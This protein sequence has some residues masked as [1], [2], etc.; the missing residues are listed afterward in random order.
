MVLVGVTPIEVQSYGTDAG[1]LDELRASWPPAGAGSTPVDGYRSTDVAALDVVGAVRLTDR[2]GVA[3]DQPQARQVR[4]ASLR[5]VL[6]Q[7]EDAQ[8]AKRLFLLQLSQRRLFVEG[9]VEAPQMHQA[10]EGDPVGAVLVLLDLLEAHAALFGKRFLRHADGASTD[11]NSRA[12]R[13]VLQAILRMI[14]TGRLVQ[15]G[16]KY[17]L[18]RHPHRPDTT[19]PLSPA[20]SDQPS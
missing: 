10:R 8:R 20:R 6:H 16:I 1:L 17:A 3:R 7:V 5:Q 2:L 13:D 4:P 15:V 9:A 18:P 14:V 11:P 19:P 12:K